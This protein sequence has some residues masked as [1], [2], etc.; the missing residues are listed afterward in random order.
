MEEV[1]RVD[2]GE[3]LLHRQPELGEL[4]LEIERPRRCDRDSGDIELRRVQVQ[5]GGHEDRTEHRAE[6]DDTALVRGRVGAR[7]GVGV[8]VGVRVRVRVRARV[9]IRVMVRIRVTVT[10]RVR[11][12]VS[13]GDSVS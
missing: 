11:V 4:H 2:E 8:G 3:V 1:E 5:D 12:K 10:V 7:V 9:K 6:L 13:V